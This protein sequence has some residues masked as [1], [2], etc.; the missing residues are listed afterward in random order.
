VMT[1]TVAALGALLI[2]GADTSS[3]LPRPLGVSASC[4]IVSQMPT[5]FTTPVIHLRFDRLAAHWIDRRPA[6]PIVPEAPAE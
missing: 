2:L 4:L 1:A 6:A 5:L 3:E